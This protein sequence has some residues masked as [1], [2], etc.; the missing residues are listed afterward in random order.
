[1]TPSP[2]TAS[3]LGLARNEAGRRFPHAEDSAVLEELRAEIVDILQGGQWEQEWKVYDLDALTTVEMDHLVE[4]GL[5]TP[6]FADSAGEGRGFAVYGEGQASIEI[7]GDDHIRVLGFRAGDRLDSLWSL[8]NLVD[9]R[10]ETVISYA[11]DPHWGYLTARPKQSG[12]GMRAYATLMVPA[13]MLTGRLAGTAVELAAQGLGIIPLWN[14]AGGVVQVS[15]PGPQGKT[16]AETLQQIADICEEI[17][18]KERSVRKV[19]LRENPIQ[20]RDQIGRALGAAQ[21]AW[22]VSFMEAVNLISAIQVGVDA[23][24]VQSPALAAESA[25]ALMS[26]LQPAHIV[27]DRMNGRTGC[28]ESPEIDEHRA[29]VL[30][31]R[32]ADT[33]VRS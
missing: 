5:M 15:N 20:T 1:V 10:L 7:N 4:R 19:L 8:L 12:T 28:L 11:F 25:F 26:R 23:G 22:S 3:A 29:L 31:E 13:L 27:V 9:D 17:I 16:E 18:E 14:G 33:T 2:I 32:F 21:Q 24:L 6:V 30:R